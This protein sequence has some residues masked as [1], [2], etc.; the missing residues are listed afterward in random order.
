MPVGNA[1]ESS[2]LALR[3]ALDE[4]DVQWPLPA[5]GEAPSPMK[6]AAKGA[7]IEARD[8]G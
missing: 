3:R 5:V 7:A 8:G 6:I 1:H 2:F 4:S